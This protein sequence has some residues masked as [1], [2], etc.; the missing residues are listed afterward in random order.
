MEN[1]YEDKVKFFIDVMAEQ[2]KKK[3]DTIPEGLRLGTYCTLY[4]SGLLSLWGVNVSFQSEQYIYIINQEKKLGK[5][6]GT[7]SQLG[8]NYDMGKKFLFYFI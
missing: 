7:S 3:Y 8:Q 6:L 5:N 1:N 2:T 4:L